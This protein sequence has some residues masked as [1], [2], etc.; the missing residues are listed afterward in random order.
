[1]KEPKDA[2]IRMT[3]EAKEPNGGYGDPAVIYLTKS[4]SRAFFSWFRKDGAVLLGYSM[5]MDLIRGKL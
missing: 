1:M 3:L 2:F 4:Q 5:L